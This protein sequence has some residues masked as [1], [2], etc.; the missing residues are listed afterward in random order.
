MT[1]VAGTYDLHLVALSFVVACFASYTA[2]DLAGRIRASRGW[3]WGAWLATAAISMGGGIWSMHFIAML[4]FIMPM[5]VTFAVGLT[6][7]SLVVAILV[8]GGGFYVIG[9]RR[10]TVL[11]LS[12][13]GVFMGIGIVAMH[14][15]GM[16]AMRMS[17]E[18][19]YDRTLVALSVVIA[20]GASIAALW[21]AFRT[22][23]AWQRIAA[24][25]VMGFAISGMHYTGMAAAEFTAHHDLNAAPTV[26]GLAQTNLAIG[27]AAITFLILF[28]A[29]LASAFDRQSAIH[30]ERGTILLR[31]SEERLRKLYRE[32]PLPLHAIGPDGR[33]EE[34][35]DAWLDLL[36]YTR[37]EALGRK[38]TDLMTPESGRRY[39]EA[40]KASLQQGGKIPQAEYQ[41]VRKTGEILDALLSAREE[42]SRG[43][44]ARTLGGLIDITT[45]KRV[46]EA[47]RQS[48]RMEAIGQLT[49]G[50]AHDF[51]NLLMVINGA[52]EIAKRSIPEKQVSLP[53]EMIVTA[54]RRG[55][56]LTGQLLSFARRQTL[57][58]EVIDLAETLPHISEMLKRSLRGDIEI[59]AFAPDRVCRARVD[60]GELELA[61]LN[62]GVNARDAM[63]NGGVLSL[64]VRHVRLSGEVEADG[65]RGEFVAIEMMDCGIGIAPEVLPRVF[66]P[67]FTTKGAGKGTGLGLS[68]VYGFAKQSGGTAIIQSRLGR[69]T[70]VT[71]YLPATEEP[72]ER[73]HPTLAD[74][75][76]SQKG[77]ALLV[78]DN[79]EVARVSAAYLEQLGYTVEVARNGSDAL[80]KLK[81]GHSYDLVFSDLLMPGS[82]AGLELAQFVRSNHPQI[83][84]LLTTGYSQKAQEAVRE[85]FPILRKPY[86]LQS[87]FKA[88][89]ELRAKSGLGSVVRDQ[90]HVMVVEDDAL[91]LSAI[92]SLLEIVGYR[93]TG[94]ASIREA[95]KQAHKQEDILLLITDFHLANG[96]LGTEV[97]RSIRSVLGRDV[98]AFLLTGDTSTRVQTIARENDAILI[99][100]PINADEFLGLLASTRESGSSFDQVS[101]GSTPESVKT[102]R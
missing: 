27:I 29:L 89:C 19:S 46:E 64:A 36:G 35:S 16:A 38:L 84:I 62:L 50:V 80:Q 85:G 41:F 25:V 100:K 69:S 98:Q 86:D 59:K 51:N 76:Q 15:T 6:A 20:I 79:E 43:E 78:E 40:V 54:V 23:A 9:I 34:S 56:K 44:P 48:Q 30:A 18:I 91:V 65:L 28:L 47:L 99:S 55:Q 24:A 57:E 88:I 45:R 93:V 87:L 31:E 67:Y 32:T 81:N 4:A 102:K 95:L 1:A 7:L 82:V 96:E 5:V 52:A 70:T 75:I 53:L 42:L 60:P 94:V 58:T 90:A 61:L 63:P 66:D 2:L 72:V 10:A 14:Y 22:V 39:Q 33:I 92:C 71:I 83:P 11:Q 17:A 26:A 101:A 73:K 97:I 74:Q 3:I 49:G 21:L 8:T 77:T 68:Q 12:L 37:E 13:S